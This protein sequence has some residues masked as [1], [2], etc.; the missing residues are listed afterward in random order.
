MGTRTRKARG[1]RETPH[2][3]AD[4][5]RRWGW[6]RTRSEPT[7]S[8]AIGPAA[9]LGTSP[10]CEGPGRVG[11]DGG[12]GEPS[13]ALAR[14]SHFD[15][16]TQMRSDGVAARRGSTFSSEPKMCG[17]HARGRSPC[18][19]L[20]RLWPCRRSVS[21]WMS[22]VVATW[23]PTSSDQR[24]LHRQSMRCRFTTSIWSP[25]VGR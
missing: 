4:R 17:M 16:P 10:S 25:F 5:A 22:E 8:A 14:P 23:S 13:A 2:C 3:G 15:M 9:W 24:L 11:A 20:R 1:P 6:R 18:S 7:R 12:L 21:W 19:N